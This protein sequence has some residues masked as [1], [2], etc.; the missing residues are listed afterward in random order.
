MIN[1]YQIEILYLFAVILIPVIFV[2]IRWKKISVYYKIALFSTFLLSSIFLIGCARD[3][4]YYSLVSYN[5]NLE[6]SQAGKK[7]EFEV[8][9]GTLLN[10]FAS[11]TIVHSTP[12]DVEYKS[13]YTTE[14]P[15]TKNNEL[16]IFIGNQDEDRYYTKTFDGDRVYGRFNISSG[17]FDYGKYVDFTEKNKKTKIIYKFNSEPTEDI[18]SMKLNFEAME[19]GDFY[20]AMGYLWFFMTIFVY[21]SLVVVFV[22]RLIIK[23]VKRFINR[24]REVN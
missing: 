17:D 10:Y 11:F 12:D 24:K 21:G 8:N 1:E 18:E 4:T 23:I 2:L 16:E 6:E 7:Y 9:N 13:L 20:E 5:V 15:E 19:S 14:W 3:A 22:I